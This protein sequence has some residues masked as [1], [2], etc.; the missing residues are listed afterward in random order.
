MKKVLGLSTLI[1]L[2]TA[3]DSYA[4]AH[5]NCNLAPIENCLEQP[6]LSK[7]VMYNL[8]IALRTLTKSYLKR[9]VK[10]QNKQYLKSRY[11][12]LSIQQA[13]SYAVDNAY[14]QMEESLSNQDKQHIIS[15]W[16]KKKPKVQHFDH[17][18][19]CVRAGDE[20]VSATSYVLGDSDGEPN[21]AE[22]TPKVRRQPLKPYNGIRVNM[23]FSL[24]RTDAPFHGDIIEQGKAIGGWSASL[25][26]QIAVLQFEA[27]YKSLE[28]SYEQFNVSAYNLS[29][30]YGIGSIT[31]PWLRVIAPSVGGGYQL[32]RIEYQQNGRINR[33][34]NNGL[35]VQGAIS[36]NPSPKF[37]IQGRY[38]RLIQSDIF[39][40]EVYE[41][42]LKIR[43]Y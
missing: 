21:M 19:I 40:S 9:Q 34:D 5:Q 37:S 36:I 15:I 17:C 2:V 1:F 30:I 22:K 26:Y 32:G 8:S 7:D 6:T 25:E 11:G 18:R 31:L 35:I 38:N 12:N 23:S 16:N 27:G 10:Q 13:A 3:I 4:C 43:L 20:I 42:G 33:A 24:P 28:T 41:V 29:N 39:E 14:D